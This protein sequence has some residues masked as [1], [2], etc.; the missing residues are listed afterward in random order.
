MKNLLL[1]ALLPVILGC[2]N[3]EVMKVEIK[4]VDP[5]LVHLSNRVADRFFVMSKNDS[6]WFGFKDYDFVS[7]GLHLFFMNETFG[8]KF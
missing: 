6:T 5:K 1:I 4:D 8:I 3:H 7:P 2:H